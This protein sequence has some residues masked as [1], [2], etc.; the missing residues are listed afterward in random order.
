MDKLKLPKL[1]AMV[2]GT[3]LAVFILVVGF[4][5]M[6]GIPGRA[7]DQQPRDVTVSEITSNSAKISYATGINTQ[8]VV[9]YGVTSTALNLLSPEG[10]SDINHE[11]ELTLLSEG[12]TYYFQIAIGD[13]KY[14]NVGVP[15]TFSTKTSDSFLFEDVNPTPTVR[16]SPSAAIPNSAST[17]EETSCE[18]IKLKLGQG[19]LTQDYVKCIKKTVPTFA[20]LTT[21]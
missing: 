1:P 4:M 3:V 9:E 21:P 12:T 15:W 2:V 19:C 16:P 13:K 6:Q 8:G 18:K 17:C 11:I 20:P 10:E 7:E 5:L 14:D